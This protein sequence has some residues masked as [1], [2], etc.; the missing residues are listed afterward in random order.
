MVEEVSAPRLCIALLIKSLAQGGAERQCCLLANQLA[1]AGHDVYIVVYDRVDTFYASLLSNKVTIISL[2]KRRWNIP[3][4]LYTLYW[5]LEFIKP[6]MLYSYMSHSNLIALLMKALIRLRVVCGIRA[7]GHNM[8]AEPLHARMGERLHR[9]ALHGADL[10]ITN[11]KAAKMEL[12]D[13]GMPPT[14]LTE[15]ANG[16]DTGRFRFDSGARAEIRATLGFTDHDCVI[17][18]F[19]RLHPM[20]GHAV[21]FSAFEQ[22][23]RSNPN[24]RLLCIGAGDW[25]GYVNTLSAKGLNSKVCLLD[26][27]TDIERY[28]S[29]IDMYC[30]ASLYGEG[31]PNALAEAM[32]TGVP[33]IA[34]D[35]GDSALILADFGNVVAAG[36]A[37]QL[38]D[39]LC[40]SSYKRNEGEAAARRQH[41]AQN[42]GLQQFGERTIAQ[43]RKIMGS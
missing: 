30:S 25:N 23:L 8:M 16:I 39:A 20:K 41:I 17:G 3:G 37:R 7:S 18:L 22:A 11:S 33:C 35:V 38:A 2:A 1:E 6:D 5:Q 4:I 34:T 19:A 29:A 32:A 14:K 28:Y 9:F 31:F 24:L 43:L 26:Q 42:F 13:D 40:G 21:M 36:D 15:V 12:L 27:C 10:I